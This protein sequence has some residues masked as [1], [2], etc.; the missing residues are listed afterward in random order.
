MDSHWG[1]L[2]HVKV[3]Y[4]KKDW[5]VRACYRWDA[6]LDP[7]IL[8]SL[9]MARRM[10]AIRLDLKGEGKKVTYLWSDAHFGLL[11]KVDEA[12]GCC[13]PVAGWEF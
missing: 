2:M 12:A 5:S 11:L 4:A 10:I 8:L 13:A 7:G 3:D 6:E 9:Q 1:Y